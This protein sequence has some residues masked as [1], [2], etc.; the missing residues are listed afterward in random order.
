MVAGGIGSAVNIE[1]G[2]LGLGVGK[3]VT[4]GWYNNHPESGVV[5]EGLQLPF[6]REACELCVRAHGLARDI[7]VIGWD[8]G[9]LEN[10]P[11]LIEANLGWDSD[12]VQLSGTTALGETAAAAAL[13]HF[14]LPTDRQFQKT[15]TAS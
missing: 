5:F 6:W 1:K 7:P 11:V 4:K 3:S 12:I 8:V 14:L 9:I 2:T 15:T 10:G 13:R